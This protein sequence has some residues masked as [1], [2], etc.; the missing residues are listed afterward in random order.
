MS[1][2]SKAMYTPLALAASVGGGIVAGA[3]FGQLWK[4]VAGESE[5]PDPKD[6]SRSTRE[7]LIAAALQGIIFGLVRAAIDRAGARGYR[8]LAHADPR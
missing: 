5:A 8:K 3:V 4:R 1:A 2:V 6:L 7:V